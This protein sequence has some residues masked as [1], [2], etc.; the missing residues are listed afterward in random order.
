MEG[1]REAAVANNS[2]LEGGREG[3]GNLRSLTRC[4]AAAAQLMFLDNKSNTK[5]AGPLYSLLDA[6]ITHTHGPVL[7][8]GE[9]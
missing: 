8:E 6:D 2:I 7:L 1:G 9:R 3:G 4:S 5:L